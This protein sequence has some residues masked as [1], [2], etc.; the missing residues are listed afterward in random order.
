MG[1]PPL[2]FE[3]KV[4][5]SAADG[6]A[7]AVKIEQGTLRYSTMADALAGYVVFCEKVKS[8]EIGE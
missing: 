6:N 8:G 5:R 3:T 4:S 1:E 2:W 7:L